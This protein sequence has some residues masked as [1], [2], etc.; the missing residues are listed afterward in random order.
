MEFEPGDQLRLSLVTQTRDSLN[1][2]LRLP[3]KNW[4]E[5]RHTINY[6]CAECKDENKLFLNKIFKQR[7]SKLPKSFGYFEFIKIS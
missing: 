5:T 7:G 6:Y 4:L 2:F 3:L 1:Y